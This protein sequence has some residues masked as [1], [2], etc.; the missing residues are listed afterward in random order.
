MSYK[1]SVDL[2]FNQTKNSPITN[3]RLPITQINS[4]ITDYQLSITQNK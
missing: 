2:D 1:N 4:P 3:D